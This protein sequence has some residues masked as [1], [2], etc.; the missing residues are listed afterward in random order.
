MKKM[1]WITV[2]FL[3]AGSL[4]SAGCDEMSLGSARDYVH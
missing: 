3:L 1:T 2:A 4:L